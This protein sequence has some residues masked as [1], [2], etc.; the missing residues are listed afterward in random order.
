M[1]LWKHW[2][3]TVERIY[4]LERVAIANLEDCQVEGG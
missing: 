3:T 4:S 2:S 1:V